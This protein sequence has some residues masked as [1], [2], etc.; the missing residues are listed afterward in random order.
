[1]YSFE[2][3]DDF[4]AFVEERRAQVQPDVSE[5]EEDEIEEMDIDIQDVLYDNLFFNGKRR[6]HKSEVKELIDRKLI[7]DR[8]ENILYQYEG[9]ELSW[10]DI[11]QSCPPDLLPGVREFCKFFGIELIPPV[12]EISEERYWKRYQSALDTYRRPKDFALYDDAESRYIESHLRDGLHHQLESPMYLK[13]GSKWITWVS[14]KIVPM[15]RT[16]QGL[17]PVVGTKIDS[18]RT[19]P[20]IIDAL[21]QGFDDVL[22]MKL[23]PKGRGVILQLRPEL[24][25]YNGPT[26]G[27]NGFNEDMIVCLQAIVFGEITE[28]VR[29]LQTPVAVWHTGGSDPEQVRK[30]KYKA[31]WD[32]HRRQTRQQNF[33]KGV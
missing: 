16:K 20:A 32:V 4:L 29:T 24:A 25:A 9:L 23:T 22:D 7:R 18:K 8:F 1:M 2:E 15:C 11:E 13:Y 27:P 3:V 17:F 33:M 6:L 5:P 21:W 26:K 14:W 19:R 28:Y 31:K 30:A 12:P 10:Q